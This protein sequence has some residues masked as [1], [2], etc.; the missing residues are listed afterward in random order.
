MSTNYTGNPIA[1]QSPSLAPG[2]GSIPI[3][4]VPADG[5][6][7]AGATFAQGYK[8]MVD[9]FAYHNNGR[10]TVWRPSLFNV[11]GSYAAAQ[12]PIPNMAELSANISGAGALMAFVGASALGFANTP[13]V[14]GP[15]VELT[16]G[17]TAGQYSSIFSSKQ[18]VPATATG[19]M[20]FVAEFEVGVDVSAS[21]NVFVGLSDTSDLST[22]NYTGIRGTAGSWALFCAGASVGTIISITNNQVERFRLECY[23]AT[24]PQGVANGGLALTNAYVQSGSNAWTLAATSNHFPAFLA[25][26]MGI[27]KATTTTQIRVRLLPWFTTWN[28]YF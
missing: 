25:Y 7:D 26:W 27:V 8:V 17:N 3:A 18:L 4:S 20:T 1:S 5:D 13:Q 2:P 22:S 23:G 11:I 15:S 19:G 6:P 9:N 24:T 21:G 14:I 12:T 10:A 28:R 16:A